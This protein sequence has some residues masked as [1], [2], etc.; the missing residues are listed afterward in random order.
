MSELTKPQHF[1]NNLY[2]V[3][4]WN[5]SVLTASTYYDFLEWNLS[6]DIAQ[7]LWRTPLL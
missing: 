4:M 6:G 3:L 1:V 5:F 2:N 7:S